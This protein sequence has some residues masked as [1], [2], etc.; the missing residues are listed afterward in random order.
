MTASRLVVLLRHSVRQGSSSFDDPL[1]AVAGKQGA[2]V[3][4]DALLWGVLLQAPMPVRG[5]PF[6]IITS[7]LERC[8]D[9][10]LGVLHKLLAA[11]FKVEG[12]RI[13]NCLAEESYNMLKLAGRQPDALVTD[14]LPMHQVLRR[15]AERNTLLGS[16]GLDYVHDG[17]G[18]YKVH[19]LELPNTDRHGACPR[20]LGCVD[21]CKAKYPDH[22]LLFVGHLHLVAS[23]LMRWKRDVW[24]RLG[25]ATFV[26]WQEGEG[27]RWHWPGIPKS[28]NARGI[29]H[30]RSF[31]SVKAC[32]YPAT[33]ARDEFAL[34]VQADDPSAAG[35]STYAGLCMQQHDDDGGLLELVMA[36]D[37]S[38]VATSPGVKQLISAALDEMES[39]PVCIPG[40]QKM[41]PGMVAWARLMVHDESEWAAVKQRRTQRLREFCHKHLYEVD[42]RGEPQQPQQQQPPSDDTAVSKMY[43]FL[44]QGLWSEQLHHEVV[45][46]YHQQGGI[47]DTAALEDAVEA[48]RAST[49]V[50]AAKCKRRKQQQA[51]MAAMLTTG[52]PDRGILGFLWRHPECRA[53]GVI[54]QAVKHH[55]YSET[56]GRTMEE[57]WLAAFA[58]WQP[59]ND[60]E[61]S[62]ED[63]HEGVLGL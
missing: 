31:K 10:S 2:E 11:G 58:N 48:D 7:P 47:P 32:C 12:M 41:A 24:D 46:Q 4:A 19:S 26:A 27:R 62:E 5:R 57:G 36:H 61:M 51:T 43:V 15:T 20:M 29:Q 16:L 28:P 53:Q 1:D 55:K 34:L 39:D 60:G 23:Q 42:E 6:M 30:P 18:D 9:T 3:A 49:W 21:W 33:A 63:E 17:A 8:I 50:T 37:A 14:L 59:G 13:A 54:T 40:V 45:T 38:Q 22:N 56:F 25:F 44:Y 52:A 35:A